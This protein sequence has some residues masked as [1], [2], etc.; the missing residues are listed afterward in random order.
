MRISRQHQGSCM[1]QPDILCMKL[2][3][4]LIVILMAVGW[5]ASGRAEQWDKSLALSADSSQ[6]GRALLYLAGNDCCDCAPSA[7][8][9]QCFAQCNAL[10]PRC[11]PPA[12]RQAAP[13]RRGPQDCD[14]ALTGF[15][16]G[17]GY[18]TYSGPNQGLMC[19][20]YPCTVVVWHQIGGWQY[21]AGQACW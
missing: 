21:F 13:Q 6:S 19:P 8:D 15:C 10:I 17:N 4:A 9:A 2:A 12:P 3:V 18:R 1:R 14:T 16:C 7:S 20:G 5:T 11:R